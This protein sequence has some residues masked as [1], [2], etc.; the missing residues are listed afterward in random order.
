MDSDSDPEVNNSDD[1]E[2][3]DD[4]VVKNKNKNKQKAITYNDDS[5]EEDDEEENAS[6][7]ENEQQLDSDKEVEE[8]EES[9]KEMEEQDDEDIAQPKIQTYLNLEEDDDNDD[10]NDDDDDDDNIN[11]L[12]K[13]DINVNKNYVNEFHP[14]CLNHNYDEIEKLTILVRDENNNIIDPFHKTVPFLTKYEKTRVIGQ[15]AK[16]IEDGAN[17]FIKVPENVIEG[18]IIAEMELKEKKIPFIIR[19]PVPGG[20]FEYWKLRDLEMIAF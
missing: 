14:E 2:D 12:Q 15:R 1:E 3:I 6:E 13:F 17:P 16:Q 19:R 18:Y 4:G 9:E 7:S 20:A 11:Y 8:A 5:D 10:D